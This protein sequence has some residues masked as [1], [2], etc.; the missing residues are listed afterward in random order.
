M[1]KTNALAA[2]QPTPSTTR[3]VRKKT[4]ALG[5]KHTALAAPTTRSAETNLS[6]GGGA[7]KEEKMGKNR[8]I[9]RE[10]FRVLLACMLSE[11]RASEGKNKDM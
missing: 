1:P 5:C 2:S 10:R 3:R 7:E 8:Q 11:D 4:N 6:G 9:Q